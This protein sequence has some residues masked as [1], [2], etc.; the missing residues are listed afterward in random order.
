M[1][2]DL[3]LLPLKPGDHLWR[4]LPGGRTWH[5]LFIG[6]LMLMPVASSSEGIVDGVQVLQPPGVVGDS[7]PPSVVI[8]VSDLAGVASAARLPL[9]DF[10]APLPGEA[11]HASS[12]VLAGTAS[13]RLY[14]RRPR[15]RK[16]AVERALSMVGRRIDEGALRLFPELIPWWAIFDEA[17]SFQPGL[18]QSRARAKRYRLA[19]RG[20]AP[21]SAAV[22]NAV[23][24]GG[25]V[26]RQ[27][28][29][30]LRG[31]RL[32]R[33]LRL[34]R[35]AAAGWTNLGGFVGERLASSLLDDG[36]A[37]T[38]VA[39]A[40][41]GWAGGLVG[42]A[43]ASAV[44]AEALGAGSVAGGLV[45]CGAAGAAGAVA[46]AGMAYAARKTLTKSVGSDA[47]R[48]AE[49]HDCGLRLMGTADDIFNLFDA[50]LEFP[51][52]DVEGL[53]EDFGEGRFIAAGWY[54][55][56]V[57]PGDLPRELKEAKTS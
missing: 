49:F 39:T 6:Q 15:C 28:R 54:A 4:P 23:L 34:T 53:T 33:A 24:A 5:G 7:F 18:C 47:D 42:G 22:V 19:P 51:A 32:V 12:Q 41:G 35:A 3:T 26:V 48:S 57:S 44:G 40:A 36:D 43:A 25:A 8:A 31:V 27:G 50:T 37:G 2:A 45:V 9:A 55:V 10:V 52:E 11:D 29:V 16:E 13:V 38:A 30:V 56:R 14:T 1:A 21:A 17:E 20:D 46:G